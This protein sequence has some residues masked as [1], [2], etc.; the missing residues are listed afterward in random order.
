MK[1]SDE[2]RKSLVIFQMEKARTTLKQAEGNVTLCF[3]EVVANRLYYACFHAVSALLIEYGYAFKSHEGLVNL[4]GMHFVRTNLV[5]IELGRFLSQLQSMR[6]KGDYNC[7]YNVTEEDIS[8]LIEPAK[9]LIAVADQLITSH[10]N[11]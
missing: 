4:F 7:I 8:P 3:W 9:K 6:E 11:A 10:T 1:L 2:E 5:D